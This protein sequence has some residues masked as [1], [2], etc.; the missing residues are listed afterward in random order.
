MRLF[1]TLESIA[2]LAGKGEPFAKRECGA[3]AFV[4]FGYPSGVA[5][6][7]EDDTHLIDSDR[8]SRVRSVGITGTFA[9]KRM[10]PA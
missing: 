3:A 6:D 10:P 5:V 8:S 1:D 9:C 7:A 4:Q 2:K